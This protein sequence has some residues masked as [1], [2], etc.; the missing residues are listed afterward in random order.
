[1]EEN[2]E[3]LLERY[4][5]GETEA[6]SILIERYRR[7]LYSFILKMS[8]SP[9]DADDVFQEVWLR[10]IHKAGAYR[11]DRFRGWVYRITHNLMIDRSRSH[12]PTVSLNQAGDDVQGG[13]WI[14]GLRSKERSPSVAALG[15]EMAGS[16]RAAVARLPPEQRE[17]FL[18][19][20]ENDVP[21]KDIAKAQGV[22]I[23]TALARM[24]YATLK[25]RKLLHETL[26]TVG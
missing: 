15:N 2:D 26:K 17:V 9:S 10:V 24:Q 19:R 7:P 18:L 1:M 3:D 4:K 25:L 21:F 8:S 12:R 14:D 20:V 6:L 16:I 22:S 23:N 13:T 5:T 11:R